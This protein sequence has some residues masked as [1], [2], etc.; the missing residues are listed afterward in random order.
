MKIL[1]EDPVPIRDRRPDLP[2]GLAAIIHRA[3]ARD[4]QARYASVREMRRALVPFATVL[5]L[6]L[7]DPE[8]ERHHQQA[9][10]RHYRHFHGRAPFDPR[11]IALVCCTKCGGCIKE[12]RSSLRNL[13]V[14]E[15]ISPAKTCRLSK[16]SQ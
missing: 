4:P 1:L 14:F 6:R 11:T 3:L 12:E 2:E 8:Y 5:G 9:D 15:T 10:H 7:S 16:N 13:L